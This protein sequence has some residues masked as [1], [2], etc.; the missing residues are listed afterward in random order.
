[1]S[2][3]TRRTAP[4]WFAATIAGV[5]GLFY[6]YAV[7]AGVSYLVVMAQ[8]ASAVGGALTPVSWIAMIMTIVVPIGT[9][10]V[11]VLLGRRREAWK[12]ILLLL[13]GLALTAVF[14]LNVQ[15]FTATQ[16]VFQ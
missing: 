8:T 4:T 12:L 5:F 3:R 16:V 14:W 7:W 2:T 1:M 10:V 13:V 15:G 9:F 6:A 11:A